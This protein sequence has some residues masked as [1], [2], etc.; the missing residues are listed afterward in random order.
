MEKNVLNLS[1]LIAFLEEKQIDIK[2]R[3]FVIREESSMFQSTTLYKIKDKRIYRSEYNEQYHLANQKIGQI[4][5]ILLVTKVFHSDSIW[6]FGRFS[7]FSYKELFSSKTS[8][9]NLR[10]IYLYL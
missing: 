10:C 2:P 3:I 6:T 8:I 5:D 1:F 7:A 9:L 4:E